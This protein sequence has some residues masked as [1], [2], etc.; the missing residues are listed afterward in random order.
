MSPGIDGETLK[1][2]FTYHAPT[3]TQLADYAEIRA[4]GL[5][6]ARMIVAHT[7][8]SADQTAALRKVREAVA[9]ANMSIACGGR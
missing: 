5:E 6:F 8:A 3:D 2:W 1:N 9:T 4:A 7:P